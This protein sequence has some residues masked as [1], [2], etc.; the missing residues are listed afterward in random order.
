MK[1]LKTLW[2]KLVNTTSTSPTLVVVEEETC[3]GMFRQMCLDAGVRNSDLKSGRV[4]E[5][6][7]EWYD[8]PCD[9]DAI[10]DA[11][12]DFKKAYGSAAA[13]L[14]GKI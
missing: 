4:L 8:G 9:E 6:F 14:Q 11:L 5:H 12:S 13:K 7:E 2:N 3:T 1:L 10:K